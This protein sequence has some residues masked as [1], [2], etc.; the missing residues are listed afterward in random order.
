MAENL[1]VEVAVVTVRC[2]EILVV[3]KSQLKLR[4]RGADQEWPGEVRMP[5]RSTTKPKLTMLGV[6][7]TDEQIARVDRLAA[8]LSRPGIRITRT[9][10]LRA[11]LEEGLARLL[12]EH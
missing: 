5:A 8:K 1:S 4:V 2:S 6:R 9:D 3:S 11:A 7:L 10:A 12:G